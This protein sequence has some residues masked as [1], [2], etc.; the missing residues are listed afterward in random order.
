MPFS[1]AIDLSCA[2]AGC[3][4]AALAVLGAGAADARP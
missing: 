4:A 1:R 2:I 3:L